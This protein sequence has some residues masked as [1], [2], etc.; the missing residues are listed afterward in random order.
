MSLSEAVRRPLLD[1]TP[2]PRRELTPIPLGKRYSVIYADP[3]WLYRLRSAKGEN[4][5]PQRHYDCMT[6]EQLVA[7]RE[8]IQLDFICEPDCALFMW[9]TW[10]I[11]AI[12]RHVELMRAWGFEPKTGSAWFKTTRSGKATFG[13]GYLLRSASE[14]WFLATR[15]SP[16]IVSHSE[17]GTMLTDETPDALGAIIANRREHSEKPND[18]YGIIERL[19][20]N[21]RYLE[22][23]GRQRRQ[24]WD[25]YGDFFGGYAPA[26]VRVRAEPAA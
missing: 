7:F 8:T 23:F 18:M 19:Y 12:G 20:P 6:F 4:K 3:P 5:A 25:V 14:P 13:T 16:R 1:P 22:L 26:P 9:A 10:P 21:A 15:G 11:V 17:R 2:P 24:K